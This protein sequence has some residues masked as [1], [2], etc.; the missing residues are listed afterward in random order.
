MGQF[1]KNLNNFMDLSSSLLANIYS[2]GSAFVNGGIFIL[3]AGFVVFMLLIVVLIIVS[4]WKI[5]V[6]AGK[7]GWASLIPI[8]NLV[9][10]LR[11]VKKPWWWIFLLLIPYV[12]MVVG[13]LVAYYLAKAFGKDA[14]FTVGMVI[15][16]FIF[17]PILAFG[18]SKY[19]A[20]AENPVI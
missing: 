18:Q 1:I 16:P 12:S 7:P 13:I 14:W 19:T 5:F 10:V 3:G 6:K 4:H 8:Y 20:P 11:I 17:Y 15:L 9:I 2:G